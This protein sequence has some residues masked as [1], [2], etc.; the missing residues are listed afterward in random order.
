M[1]MVEKCISQEEMGTFSHADILELNTHGYEIGR[2]TETVKAALCLAAY[3][4]EGDRRKLANMP[5]LAHPFE[6]MLMVAEIEGIDPYDVEPGSEAEASL[7][8]ALLHDTDED[9]HGRV[10]VAMV[11]DLF[12]RRIAAGVELATRD[13][14]QTDEVYFGKISLSP[15]KPALRVIA[16]DKSHA[17]TCRIPELY[18][19]KADPIEMFS[20]SVADKVH[21]YIAVYNALTPGLGRDDATM[22]IFEELIVQYA[23]QIE[24]IL[25]IEVDLR[26]L[27]SDS[28]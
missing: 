2:F 25:K 17:L 11:E 21:Y 7:V 13:K 26:V 5:F 24:K 1:S 16:S 27:T 23:Q 15:D 6:T 12:G 20:M 10:S 14:S 9:S 19:L 22:R 28:V 3:A 4:H 8:M 18:K